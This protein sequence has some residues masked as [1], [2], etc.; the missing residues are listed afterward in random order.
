MPRKSASDPVL[1]NW[2]EET[3]IVLQRRSTLATEINLTIFDGSV[4]AQA[5]LPVLGNSES[6]Q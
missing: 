2:G 5:D 3:F 1:G 6:E 4:V